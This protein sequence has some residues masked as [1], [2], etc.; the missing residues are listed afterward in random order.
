M[1]ARLVRYPGALA[2]FVGSV[3]VANAAVAKTP[4]ISG[5]GWV[6][7]GII[8]FLIGVIWFLIMGALHVER[9][10][11]SLGRGRRRTDD[12][13]FGIFPAGADDE[14]DAPD[15]HRGDDGGEG[16]N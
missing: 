2:A 14:E 9:R 16:G 1:P 11:A 4:S 7:L 8:A 10:D 12:G 5:N 13:W 6:A 3:H 15:Y